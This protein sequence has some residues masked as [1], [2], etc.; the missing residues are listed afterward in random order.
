MVA[1]RPHGGAEGLAQVLRAPLP[2][3]GPQWWGFSIFVLL[4]GQTDKRRETE[5]RQGLRRHAE[6]FYLSLMLILYLLQN[7]HR[8]EQARV[9]GQG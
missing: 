1:P 9:R 8:E 3:P 7:S 6:K 5:D 4:W 2:L